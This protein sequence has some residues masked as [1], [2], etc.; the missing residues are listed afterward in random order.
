MEYCFSGSLLSVFES[1]ENVFG[2]SEDE[3]LV[4]L[5]CVGEFFLDFFGR[6]FFVLD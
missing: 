5:R 4:V 2:L 1:F 6:F 3:F